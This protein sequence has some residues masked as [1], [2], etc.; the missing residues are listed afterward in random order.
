MVYLTIISLDSEGIVEA[1]DF[2]VDMLLNAFNDKQTQ[3]QMMYSDSYEF[4]VNSTSVYSS[5]SL[6]YNLS[7]SD[8][9]KSNYTTLT[10]APN[11]TALNMSLAAFMFSQFSAYASITDTMPNHSRHA[12]SS[13]DEYGITIINI[14]T[15]DINTTCS[16]TSTWIMFYVTV[17]AA[18]ELTV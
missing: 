8:L 9:K 6:Q 10:V 18:V 12:Y 3:I 13:V 5:Y 7:C 15:S 14:A 4:S 16:A 17:N 11:I 1:V 2:E